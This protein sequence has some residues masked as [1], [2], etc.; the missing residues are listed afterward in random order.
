MSGREM[1]AYHPEFFVD[2]DE[3]MGADEYVADTTDEVPETVLTVTGTSIV[4]TQKGGGKP[5]Q[6]IHITESLFT[7]APLPED[8]DDEDEP[9]HREN[10][11]SS[12]AAAASSSSSSG[13]AKRSEHEN[14]N[15]EDGEEEEEEEQEEQDEAEEAE[16]DGAGAGSDDEKAPQRSP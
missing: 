4:A 12:P 8:E 11:S 10:G 14:G 1:F 15:E 16:E 3:A 6:P 9:P 2:D 13:G 5:L 7:D